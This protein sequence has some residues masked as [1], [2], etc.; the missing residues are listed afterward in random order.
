M[1]SCRIGYFNISILT[2]SLGP[3]KFA[4][5]VFNKT[6]K[7]V[8]YQFVTLTLFAQETLSAIG[9]EAHGLQRGLWDACR[10]MTA[11]VALTRAELAQPSH[12][13]WAALAKP[14]LCIAKN[15][16]TEGGVISPEVKSGQ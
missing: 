12:V 7:C 15:G 14:V 3:Y 9:A 13:E 10:S 1:Y 16:E 4:A 11:G 8:L 5:Q 2:C 6:V